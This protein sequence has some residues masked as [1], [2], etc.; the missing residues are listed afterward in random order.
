MPTD[1]R[2]CLSRPKAVALDTEIARLLA[3]IP[4]RRVGAQRKVFTPQQDALIL[5]GYERKD[6]KALAAA[7]GCHEGTLLRRYRELKAAKGGD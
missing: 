1:Q 4:D 6:R 5:A 2:K 3:E 7:V